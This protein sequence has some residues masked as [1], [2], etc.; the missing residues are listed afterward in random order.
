M[1]EGFS[2]LESAADIRG[3]RKVL[4]DIETEALRN[5]LWNYDTETFFFIWTKP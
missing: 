4:F 5:L 2:A 1:V 3:W